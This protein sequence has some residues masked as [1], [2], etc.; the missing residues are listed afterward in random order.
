MMP[1]VRS[2][3]TNF[4]RRNGRSEAFK[5]GKIFVE[6]KSEEGFFDHVKKFISET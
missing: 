3:L 2:T 4:R 5:M 6:D 1:S